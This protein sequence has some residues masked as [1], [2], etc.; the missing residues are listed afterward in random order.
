MTQPVVV[1]HKG[2]EERLRGRR[3]SAAQSEEF[4]NLKTVLCAL[5]PQPSCKCTE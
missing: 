3:I 1:L 5:V 4:F 2:K